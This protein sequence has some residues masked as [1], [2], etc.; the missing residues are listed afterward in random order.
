MRQLVRE[1]RSNVAVWKELRELIFESAIT[2]RVRTRFRD[3]A[4]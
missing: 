1:L 3:W 4:I 2:L